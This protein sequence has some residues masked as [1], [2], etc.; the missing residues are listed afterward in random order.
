MVAVDCGDVKAV[1]GMG[2]E[3]EA[4]DRQGA[5]SDEVGQ[6]VRAEG[7]ARGVQVGEGS[8]IGVRDRSVVDGERRMCLAAERGR[9]RLQHDFAHRHAH[10]IP[11]RS[12]ARTIDLDLAL[13]VM[14]TDDRGRKFFGLADQIVGSGIHGC[15]PLFPPRCIL[16]AQMEPDQ[17]A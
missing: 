1:G 6:Q 12:I 13:T 10:C 3:R 2:S 11:M 14:R 16:F 17:P 8:R 4:D 9:R 5:A 15:I 7:G